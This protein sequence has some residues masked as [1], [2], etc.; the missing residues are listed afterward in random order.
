MTCLGPRWDAAELGSEPR[1]LT[2]SPRSLH[3]SGAPELQGKSLNAPNHGPAPLPCPRSP[4]LLPVGQDS[5]LKNP[6]SAG[7]S[8]LHSEKLRPRQGKGLC[9]SPSPEEP[10]PTT[11]PTPA[12][13]GPRPPPTQSPHSPLWGSNP[14]GVRGWS[15]GPAGSGRGGEGWGCPAPHI[16]PAAPPPGWAPTPNISPC[17]DARPLTGPASEPR[18]ACGPSSGSAQLPGGKLPLESLRRIGS[19][20]RLRAAWG[21]A[22]LPP[23]PEAS[24]THQVWGWSL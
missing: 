11:E 21:E 22:A 19:S 17:L 24:V 10:E 12:S 1:S 23:S 8:P 13:P 14:V 20:G 4:S 18:G 3:L 5:P 2:R 16:S 6:I 15:S 7:L 9:T